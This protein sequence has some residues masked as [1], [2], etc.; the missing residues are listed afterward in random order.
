MIDLNQLAA[1]AATRRKNDEA[2]AEKRRVQFSR[3][4][5]MQSELSLA[6]VASLI[7]LVQL[8]RHSLG[9]PA[10]VRVKLDDGEGEIEFSKESGMWKVHETPCDSLPYCRG[11]GDFK[12]YSKAAARSVLDAL[13]IHQES[14]ILDQLLACLRPLHAGE[15]DEVFA[16]LDA[17]PRHAAAFACHYG[18]RLAMAIGEE[19]THA[20]TKMFYAWFVE[21]NI[22]PGEWE[23]SEV[24]SLK[25]GLKAAKV[26]DYGKQLDFVP[27]ALALLDT[28]DGYPLQ[29]ALDAGM[30]CD[31]SYLGFHA[32]EVA[33]DH[34][35]LT[36]FKQVAETAL[37]NCED[38]VFLRIMKRYI[39]REYAYDGFNR[40]GVFRFPFQ[41][42]FWKYEGR[43]GK[44]AFLADNA[45]VRS[46]FES[47]EGLAL[48]PKVPDKKE[49][50]ATIVRKLLGLQ[51]AS[52]AAVA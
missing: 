35:P 38:A 24:V 37:V 36:V 43:V 9:F 48:L 34:C 6:G 21:R 39:D 7:T 10:K 13:G 19:E 28:K 44:F 11:D 1:K 51:P 27:A 42:H 32:L 3:L 40:Y 20:F 25:K 22:V 2:L 15:R 23:T 26:E 16:T 47:R 30:R 17:L 52:D 46:V 5:A 31:V 12:N 29:L 8:E 4:Q 14:G 45:R 50:P 41:F 49:T 33:F 18:T